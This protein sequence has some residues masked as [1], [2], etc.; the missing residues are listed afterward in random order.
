MA[1]DRGY[2]CLNFNN[3]RDYNAMGLDSKTDFYNSRHVNIKGALK[4]TSYF[5][6][7]LR[8]DYNLKDHRGDPNYKSWQ[9]SGEK[10]RTEYKKLTESM[11]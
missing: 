8:E 1:R 2:D 10:L 7:I 3:Y 6:E 11:K 4:Y 9:E 5:A